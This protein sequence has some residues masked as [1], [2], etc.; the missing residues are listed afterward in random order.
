MGDW[1]G[2]WFGDWFGPNGSQDAFA[3]G[4]IPGLTITAPLGAAQATAPPAGYARDLVGLVGRASSRRIV[5]RARGALPAPMVCTP[6]PGSA[7][8]SPP[9]RRRVAAALPGFIATAPAGVVTVRDPWG[10]EDL[11]LLTAGALSSE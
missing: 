10:E 6:P 4:A 9:A 1:F 5:R 11:L 7:R 8:V 3:S 2:G